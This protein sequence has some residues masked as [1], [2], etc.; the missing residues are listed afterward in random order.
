[1]KFFRIQLFCCFTYDEIEGESRECGGGNV[2]IGEGLDDGILA[3]GCESTDGGNMYLKGIVVFLNDNGSL[4]Y[5]GREGDY[6]PF[7]LSKISS[8]LIYGEAK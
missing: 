3:F 5:G 7:I 8:A 6:S 4:V 2:L 1:M